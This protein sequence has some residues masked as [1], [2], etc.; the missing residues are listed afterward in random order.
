VKFQLTITIDDWLVVSTPLK[1]MKVSWYD[2]SEYMENKKM[3][4]ATNQ[5]RFMK[6]SFTS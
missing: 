3:F 4:Q 1:I 5:M 6:G 2:Y